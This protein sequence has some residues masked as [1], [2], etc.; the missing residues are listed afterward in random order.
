MKK[1]RILAMGFRGYMG[2]AN[3]D[4]HCHNCVDCISCIWGVGITRYARSHKCANCVDCASYKG[5]YDRR[6]VVDNIQLTE[7]E[8]KD[9]MAR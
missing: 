1:E 5:P 8:Y 2:Q 6:Y 4:I 9:F 7:S 3:E